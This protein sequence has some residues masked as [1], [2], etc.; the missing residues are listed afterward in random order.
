MLPQTG[1]TPRLPARSARLPS[2]MGVL[3]GADPLMLPLFRAGGAGC[4]TATSNLRADALRT[5][6][7]GW[8]DPARADDVAAAQARID[9]WRTL[10]NQYVQLPTVKTMLARS[11]G[12]SGWLNLLPPLV[13]LAEGERKDVWAEME[14]LGG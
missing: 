11:R 2:S 5:V 12:D 13:E 9:D 4:I 7:E 14:K 1:M 6:W 10:T 8:Q 3:A